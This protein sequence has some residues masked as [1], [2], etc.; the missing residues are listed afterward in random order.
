MLQHPL[1]VSLRGQV[2]SRTCVQPRPSERGTKRSVQGKC[3]DNLRNPLIAKDDPRR[4]GRL[5]LVSRRKV[6]VLGC[7][8]LGKAKAKHQIGGSD[9]YFETP[10]KSEGI[11]EW[12]GFRMPR[13]INSPNFEGAST[14][15]LQT[16][17]INP[18][19]T[20]TNE[21]HMMYA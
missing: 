17:L 15:W 5:V 8:N 16:L 14:F 20:A 4:N 12:K 10:Q 1:L 19:S 13:L 7:T 2:V 6:A 3:R 11:H 18:G 21:A 9:S